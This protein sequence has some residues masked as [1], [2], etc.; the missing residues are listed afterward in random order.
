MTV[1]K[2]CEKKCYT[3]LIYDFKYKMYKCKVCYKML[4]FIRD[5]ED[6]GW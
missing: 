3:Y 1:C 4:N 6:D 2:I 5:E